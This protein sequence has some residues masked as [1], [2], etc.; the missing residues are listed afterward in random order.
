MATTET[1]STRITE[2][3][4]AIHDLML[5]TRVVRIT[6]PDGT[7]AEYSEVD[8]EKLQRYRSW[9]EGELSKTQTR[10][11]IGPGPIYILPA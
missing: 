6:S 10:S 5:G 2:V 8:L 4:T 11:S 3:E 1:L 9:L 7:Q